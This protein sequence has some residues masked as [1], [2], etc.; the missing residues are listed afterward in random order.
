MSAYALSGSNLVSFDQTN[1]T[2]GT[3]IGITGLNLGEA[4]VGIDFRPQNGFLYG[5]G[6]GA[7]A[8][9]ATL[10]AISTR[11]GQAT[12]VGGPIAFVDEGGNPVIFPTGN[13][14]FDFNPTVDRI[15][16]TTDTGLNFRIN[17]NN[18]APVDGNAGVAG[19]QPDGFINGATT[20]APAN[21]YTNSQPNVTVTTLYTLNSDTNQLLIQNP[22]NNGTQTVPINITLG[23]NPLDFSASNGFDISAGVNVATN[24]AV[25]SGSGLAALTVAGTTGLYSIDLTTGAATKVGNLLNGSTSASG[26]AIE[27]DLGGGIPA[28]AL[29]AAGDQL[30]RF[31]TATPATVASVPISGVAAGEVVVGIDFRPQTGQLYAF[32]VNAAANT[33]TLYLVDPQTGAAAA[34]GTPG[35]VTFVAADGIAPVDLPAASAGYGM[36]FNPTVDRIRITTDTGLNFRLNPNNGAAVDADVV[37]AGIQPDGAINGLP[38]GSTGASANAYTNSFGQP[39]TGGVTTL[40]TLDAAS[41]SLFIQNP[42]NAGTQTAQ[43]TVKLGGSPLDFTSVNGFDIPADVTVAASN[44]VAG[45]FGFAGLTVGGATSLYLINLVSGDA[46]NLG[47]IGAGFSTAG[48]AL[49]DSPN[50]FYLVDDPGDVVTE[51]PSGG[52]D[53]AVTGLASYSLAANVENLIGTSATGQT[54]TGNALNN[55]IT[56]GTGNN[57]IYAGDGNN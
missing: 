36:D 34:V 5:L 51:T 37:T 46:I 32:A 56:G 27:N 31:N 3:T 57:S 33:G 22:P 55:G 4:L 17:P 41:N 30:L 12:P 11:T 52:T 50:D 7:A 14:G 18:G 19:T 43:V 13:Y 26:L 9:T 38:P 47:A 35:Q 15:R 42:P 23:G 39:L 2:V 53:T 45:G 8:T 54:L 28:I 25:A 1:P 21:A 29:S 24:N 20:G 49:A 44:S 6:V 16:V 48:L 10:Y 40:Y